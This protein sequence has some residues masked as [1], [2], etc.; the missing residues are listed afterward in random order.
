[1]HYNYTL[2]AHAL[3]IQPKFWVPELFEADVYGEDWYNGNYLLG[4]PLCP[5][6]STSQAHL[7]CCNIPI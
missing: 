1:M 3:Q 6:L 4:V 7:S 5:A 2:G